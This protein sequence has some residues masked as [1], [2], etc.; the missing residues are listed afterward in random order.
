MSSYI[1]VRIS[2]YELH[3]QDGI[4][5]STSLSANFFFKKTR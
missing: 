4:T 2:K 5:G 1:K 3:V